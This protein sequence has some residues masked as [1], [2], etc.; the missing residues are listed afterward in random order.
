MRLFAVHSPPALL[1]AKNEEHLGFRA[2]L[3]LLCRAR[4]GGAVRKAPQRFYD[5][6]LTF[7]VRFRE[8]L[9]STVA[10]GNVRLQKFGHV[11]PRSFPPRMAPQIIGDFDHGVNRS[12]RFAKVS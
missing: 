1:C 6:R 8:P 10:I 7:A 3:R 4:S 2:F 12:M 5:T 9:A 11:R